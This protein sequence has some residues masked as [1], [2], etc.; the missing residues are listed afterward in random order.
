MAVAVGVAVLVPLDRNRMEAVTD[1]LVER[2]VA[3]LDLDARMRI[4]ILSARRDEDRILAADDPTFAS[5]VLAQ[6]GRLADLAG[7]G[8]RLA[9]D[10]ARERYVRLSEHAQRY[11]EA[12]SALARVLAQGKESL[13]TWRSRLVADADAVLGFLE[14]LEVELRSHTSASSAR[15]LAAADLLT[16][17]TLRVRE[18]RRLGE[19]VAE[20]RTGRGLPKGAIARHKAV[21]EEL[22]AELGEVTEGVQSRAA[23]ASARYQFASLTETLVELEG[24][25]ES[26]QAALGDKKVGAEEAADQLWAAAERLHAANRLGIQALRK[27][28]KLE[29]EAGEF[30]ILLFMGLGTLVLMLFGLGVARSIGKRIARVTGAAQRVLQGDM[31]ASIPEEVDDELAE[32]AGSFNRMAERVRTQQ[33]RQRGLN[34][35]VSLLNV[36]IGTKELFTRS[37]GAIV[38]VAGADIGAVYLTNEDAASLRLVATHALSPDAAPAE[39]I[40]FGEGIIG[41]AAEERRPRRVRPVSADA[42]TIATG[43]T[44]SSPGEVLV[45]PM[46]LGD[47]LQGV[48]ELARS[49]EF[50][51]DIVPFLEEVLAQVAV[52]AGTARTWEAL[53]RTAEELRARTSEL[54]EKT[55]AL[56]E[57]GRSLRHVNEELALAS[58]LK[59]EFLANVSHELR[60]PLN[61]IMGFTE[62]VLDKT[63]ELPARR[64]RN[65][66]SVQRNAKNLMEL[67]NDLLDLSK[68]EAGRLT[69]TPERFTVDELVDDCLRVLR[70]LAEQKSVALV[71]DVEAELPEL[72]TDRG[73]LRQIL[74]NLLSN[75]VK[76][77]DDGEVRLHAGS[78]ADPGADGEVSLTV[79]DTGIGIAAEELPRVFDK[80]HQVDGS[81]SRQRGGTG[82][83]L[84][85]S[86]DL[87]GS[88]GGGLVVQSQ[89]GEGSRFTL[90]L[91]AVYRGQTDAARESQAG[92]VQAAGPPAVRGRRTVLVVDDD[93]RAVVGLREA[94][95]PA[96]VEVRSAF[97]SDEGLAMLRKLAAHAV[98][99]DP[100]RPSKPGA[101]LA[102][103]LPP[104]NGDTPVMAIGLALSSDGDRALA[105]VFGP[106]ADGQALD[107]ALL[108]RLDGA[109]SGDAVEAILADVG[110]PSADVLRGLTSVLEADR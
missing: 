2:G 37:I 74:L 9:G 19:A 57:Q 54:Q 10:G 4:A 17:V 92:A 21:I 32:L 27:Q 35:I 69:I 109:A 51:P 104:P 28:A 41:A 63:A 71:A 76:F 44:V 87:A 101:S 100:W 5:D 20:R 59:T 42:L 80:F 13:S 49:G 11:S 43:G 64:R 62:L 73:K 82:L 56:E 50:P 95:Q 77:T 29:A 22:I 33:D 103:R 15:H 105:H 75:A 108:A 60:T 47:E 61:S 58:Q 72:Q 14:R 93:P 102:G 46:L 26:L 1:A 107:Q 83:G 68:I 36:A 53:Q 55:A 7:A 40:R 70:P 8:E 90:T 99:F 23:L 98:V 81:S 96:G 45:L 86:K 39:V 91:P 89:L 52:A 78:A 85:I 48:V 38:R 106:C 67:I 65:L 31:T 97:T 79:S 3:A 12:V 16:R 30:R 88:L 34:R 94:L 66:E 110:R 24:R 6:V 18:L 25:V 84:A